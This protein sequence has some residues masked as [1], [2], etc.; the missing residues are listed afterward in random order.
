[1]TGRERQAAVDMTRGSPVKL[2]LRFTLP[3]L[4]GQMMQQIYT[5][6]DTMIT[7]HFIGDAAIAAIGA[8][9]SLNDLMINFANGMC[10]GCGIIIGQLYG[11]QKMDKL[12]RATAVMLM[13][14]VGLGAL[15]TLGVMIGIEPLMRLLNTPESVFDEAMRYA[16]VVCG[17]VGVTILYNMCASF[18]RSLG[19][20]R[21]PLVFLTISCVLNIALDTLFVVVLHIG[22]VGTAL[23]TLI[24]QCI[25]A[26]LSMAYI[27]RAF[28]PFLPSKTDFRAPAGL[29]MQM[30]ASGLS[31]GL[32][33]SVYA[34]GSLT[35]QR[36]INTLGE[37]VMAAHTSAR[38]ILSLTGAPMSNL[39]T[40][41]AVFISQNCGAQA[42]DRVKRGLNRT[43]LMALIWEAAAMVVMVTLGPELLRLL[44]GTSNAELLRYGTMSLR[45]SA[46]LFLPLAYLVTMRQAMQA[47][48]MH[49]VPVVSSCIELVMKIAAAFAVVPRFG[50]AGAC[51]VEPATWLACC[52]FLMIQY[53]VKRKEILHL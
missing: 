23:A 39:G 19:N 17:G 36:A 49:V 4:I 45:A 53:M 48:G 44:I 40:A 7:G 33:N 42:Y 22:V 37:T 34:L 50:Y 6:T 8:S 14:G 20:G 1:M 21:M 27:A 5:L 13:F 31:M 43:V 26:L 38:R 35:M 12:R 25:S 9:T 32:M 16:A 3:L 11:A 47:L 18:M 2:I 46:A 15:L 24:A 28:K 30:A 51:W 29:W 10:N 52:V 41:G